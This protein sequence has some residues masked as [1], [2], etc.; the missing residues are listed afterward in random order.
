MK[1]IYFSF[2]AVLL[3]FIISQPLQA[4]LLGG[5]GFL[6][7]NYIEAGVR[8]NGAFGSTVAAPS[9]YFFSTNPIYGGR[10]GF[11]ADVGKD[12]WTVGSPAYIGDYF[13]P[14][15]PYEAF[16]VKMNGTLYENSGS[17]ANSIP[18]SVTGFHSDG[19]SSSVEWVGT[20]NNLQIR[21]VVTVGKTNSYILIRVFLKNTGTTTINDIYYTRSVDPDNEVDQGGDFTTINTIEQQNMN[22]TSTALVSG[23]GLNYGSYLGLGSRDCRAR[24]AIMSSFSSDGENIYKGIGSVAASAAGTTITADMAIAVAFNVGSL[25]AGD[26][27]SVAMAYVLNA[28]DLPPAMDETDPLFNVKADSYLSGSTL[29]VCS[30][31]TAQLNIVNGDGYTWTWSPATG[32]DKTT[33]RV[34]NATLSG[35][36]TY[37]ASGVNACGTTRSI[38]LNLHPVV[39]APPAAAGTII[40]SPVVLPGQNASF[41]VPAIANATTYKWSIPP[42]ATFVSGYGTNS[43]VINFGSTATGGALTVYGENSCG[44]GATATKNVML[45]VSISSTNEG[46]D[47]TTDLTAAT[48][49]DA[50]VQVNSAASIT[51]ARVYIEEGFRTGDVLSYGSLPSGVTAQ[52]NGAT[53]SLTF[54]GTATA[55]QWQALLRSVKFNTT[56]S[57]RG[58]RKIRFVLGSFVKLMIGG[59]AHYYEYVKP[60]TPPTW[61]EAKAAAAAK[62]LYGLTGYLATITSREENDFITTKLLGDGWIGGSDAFAQINAAKGTSYTQQSET[63]GQWHWVTGPEAGTLISTGNMSPIPIGFANWLFGEPNN[64]GRPDENFMQLLSDWEGQWND[65]P[66]SA[67]ASV[68]SYVVEYGG[69]DDDPELFIDYARIVKNTKIDAPAISNINGHSGSTDFLTSAT[70]LLFNGTAVANSTVS[71]IRTDVGVVGTATADATGNWVFDYTGTTLADGTHMFSTLAELDGVLSDTSTVWTVHIDATA[72]AKPSKPALVSGDAEHIRENQPAFSGTAEAEALVTIYNDGTVI[73]TVT[74]D[75]DGRWTFTPSPALADGMQKITVTATDKATNISEVSDTLSFVVD[76]QKPDAPSVVLTSAHNNGFTSVNTPTI[77]GTAEAGTVVT[78]FEGTVQRASITADAD[79]KWSYTFSTPLTDGEHQITLTAT[80]AAGNVSE[81][82]ASLNFTVDTQAPATPARPVLDERS[83]IINNNK[84]RIYGTAEAGAVVILY[85]K[86][87]AVDSITADADGKWSYAFP[88]A[89]ADGDHQISLTATDA[90]GNVSEGSAT[91]NFTVDTQAPAAPAMPVLV[92]THKNGATNTTRPVLSGKAEAGSTVTIYSG[93]TVVTTVMADASGNWS[94]TFTDALAD[95][96]YPVT[97]SATDAAGN[98]SDASPVL[99][100]T[101]DTQKPVTPPAA[102]LNGGVDG[103]I[104]TGKPSVSGIAEAGSVVTIYDNGVVVGTVTA[105]SDGSWSYTFNPALTDGVH[106]ITLT[107]TDDA[108]NTSS[109]SELSRINIDTQAPTVTVSAAQG[110]VKEAFLVTFRFNEAVTGFSAAGVQLTNATLVNFTAVSATEYTALVMPVYDQ[111]V[112]VSVGAG[113]AI[114][115]AHNSNVASNV[116][117]LQASFNALVE[118][119]YPNPARTSVTVSFKGIVPTQGKVMLTNMAGQVVYNSQVNFQDKKLV[120]PVSRYGAGLYILTIQAKDY[121]YR[122]QV[123]IAR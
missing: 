4:Q 123:I 72:P 55:A 90:A 37:T 50:S 122:T 105:G 114:D 118:T 95:G 27:T 87:V 22:S 62:S 48:T 63:E 9:D 102:V 83:S 116:L 8:P 51:D 30:G 49:V 77:S 15:D 18:G 84:P 91:L 16:S 32:L 1:R 36:I 47:L 29:D 66:G 28:S 38:T 41:S 76:T 108:G 104:N 21:Q 6:K 31:S 74:A 67:S 13:M 119:V 45:G 98:I 93:S 57:Y 23:K 106:S 64:S 68:P 19:T 11:I 97:I 35:D 34:V 25:A 96:T 92:S 71:I 5:N 14:G 24:V 99:Q 79:G 17:G 81:A 120:I 113:V 40:G 65:L 61:E 44:T 54:T 53:G 103:N 121:L 52:Y 115:V 70:K 33:G 56:S 110:S 42:G 111:E 75:A 86:G 3:L 80:D 73:G 117:R 2:V 59:K 112:S 60:A 43:I 10:V 88:A 26:S 100:I 85:D 7:G 89:L 58:S 69:F 107:A 109:A 94:Y 39:V 101:V 46:K 20:K 78:L 82:S 12:G